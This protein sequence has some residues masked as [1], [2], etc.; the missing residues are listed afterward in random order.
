MKKNIQNNNEYSHFNN[1]GNFNIISHCRCHIISTFLFSVDIF[2]RM[3]SNSNMS[4][5]GR[6]VFKQ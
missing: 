3:L 1:I 4:N 2:I 5:L 6:I